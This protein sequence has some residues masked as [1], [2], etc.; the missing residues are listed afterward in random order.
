MSKKRKKVI[1]LI[2]KRIEKPKYGHF[3]IRKSLLI[4]LIS[5]CAILVWSIWSSYAN[6]SAHLRNALLKSH[7]KSSI[8]E[9]DNTKTMNAVLKTIES[10]QQ[11][12]NKY[13]EILEEKLTESLW[14]ISKGEIAEK[15]SIVSKKLKNFSYQDI[16]ENDEQK[17]K[18]AQLTALKHVLQSMYDYN[19]Y[20]KNIDIDSLLEK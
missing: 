12:E 1:K 8:I 6:D 14:K 2:Q 5:S 11:L 18:Y 10:I 3:H 7:F 4:A 9:V 15:L 20:S 17:E 19:H 13:V 16:L